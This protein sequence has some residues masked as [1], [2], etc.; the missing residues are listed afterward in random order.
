MGSIFEWISRE[1]A[2]EALN[3][4]NRTIT[5]YIRNG[6]LTTLR[7]PDNGKRLLINR[8]DVKAL[9]EG[10][11]KGLPRAVN[12]LSV[13]RLDAEV[14][15]LKKQV[16]TLMRLVDVRYDPL[17]LSKDELASLWKMAHHHT[18]VPWSPYEESMWCD[19]FVRLR[20]EDIEV[21]AE[22]VDDPDPWRPFYMLAK[23]MIDHPHNGDTRLLLSAGKVNIERIGFI[24]SQKLNTNDG[25][26][27]HKMV[28]KD[29][30]LVRRLGR[31]L[32][33][34]QQKSNPPKE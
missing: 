5:E 2:R 10:R 26:D 11:K 1:R 21:M 27:V 3:V 6:Q 20:I 17:D 33:R 18:K 4:S 29:D 31:K 8:S 30:V 14:Q 24:W 34:V 32:E 15:F 28:A 12:A 16:E 25:H 19:V 7:D 9:I 13:A 23:A 22:A